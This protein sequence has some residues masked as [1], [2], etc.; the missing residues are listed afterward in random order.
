M[1]MDPTGHRNAGFTTASGKHSG[2]PVELID[3]ISNYSGAALSGLEKHIAHGGTLPMLT[4]ESVENVSKAAK[5]GGPA[6]GV[7]TT[8]FD[9]VMADT[10]RDACIAALAGAVGAGG[11]WGGVEL[12]ATLG[13]ATGPAAPVM[14]P[15][16]A[17]I[18][19]LGG[20]LGGADLGKFIGNVV[21]PY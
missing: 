20:G 17:F 15:G 10:G 13:A 18:L 3:D 2:V 11:G 16:L 8:V 1:S 9:M 4:A 21:C 5:F 6:L 7:A 14:V 19:G 12:G